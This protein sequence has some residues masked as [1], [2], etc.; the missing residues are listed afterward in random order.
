MY[1]ELALYKPQTPRPTFMMWSNNGAFNQ[2]LDAI[3]KIVDD[4]QGKLPFL[5][6]ARK[7]LRDVFVFSDPIDYPYTVSWQKGV[8]SLGSIGEEVIKFYEDWSALHEKMKAD[9][10]IARQE[11][12][13]YRNRLAGLNNRII[14]ARSELLDAV[15]QDTI[16]F[17][18]TE[19]ISRYPVV[20]QGD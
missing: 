12:E 13:A 11:L 7:F 17:S 6:K 8:Q 15:N 18:K 20:L 4:R 1:I 3:T 5:T 19:E 14:F 16:D 2:D 9:S 10:S